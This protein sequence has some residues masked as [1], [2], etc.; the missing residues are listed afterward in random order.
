VWPGFVRTER[1]D[2]GEAMGLLP[3]GLDL[4]TSESPRFMGRAVVALATAADV[5]RWSGK[6][7]S[8]RDLA[9][10]YGFTDVDGNLPAGPLRHRSD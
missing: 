8:A 2:V 10:E 3:D 7:V 4:S 9:D 6:A 1:I 5:A